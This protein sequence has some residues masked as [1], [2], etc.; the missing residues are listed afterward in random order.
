MP[1]RPARALSQAVSHSFVCTLLLLAACSLLSCKSDPA[2]PGPAASPVFPPHFPSLRV[3][4][5]IAFNSAADSAR[6]ARSVVV[7]RLNQ[8]RIEFGT[9]EG[10]LTTFQSLPYVQIS[11]T[12]W[13]NPADGGVASCQTEYWIETRSASL[14]WNCYVIGDCGVAHPTYPSPVVGMQSTLDGSEGQLDVFWLWDRPGTA[15]L[16][17]ESDAAGGRRTF[18]KYERRNQG[19]VLLATLVIRDLPDG[20]QETDLTRP[21]EYRWWARISGDG[22]SGSFRLDRPGAAGSEW[23]VADEIS[24]ASG[25]GRWTSRAVSGVVEETRW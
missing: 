24:W 18:H 19:A 21:G 16:T 8:V 11:A 15:R 22:Q 3:R 12:E 14:Q 1:G 2:G 6:Y 10:H 23:A 7:G 5:T 9:L 4:T 20:A 17:W 25:H 13:M